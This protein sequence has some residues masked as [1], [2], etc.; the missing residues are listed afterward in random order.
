MHAILGKFGLANLPKKPSSSSLDSDFSCRIG[1]IVIATHQ[2]CG[3]L[4]VSRDCKL[5]AQ[6]P[7]CAIYGACRLALTWY[8]GHHGMAAFD[9]GAGGERLAAFG[10]GER[11]C[12]RDHPRRLT[13]RTGNQQAGSKLPLF[14]GRHWRTGRIAGI[15][16]R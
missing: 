13:C 6:A 10:A 4:M 8:T 5:Y 3:N 11:L 9:H 7:R 14:P 2:G 12:D 16:V 1:I 15:A